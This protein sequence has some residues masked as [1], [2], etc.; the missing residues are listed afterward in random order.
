MSDEGRGRMR[1]YRIEDTGDQCCRQGGIGFDTAGRLTAG[2]TKG[3]ATYISA[4]LG[5]VHVDQYVRLL[6]G[7][8]AGRHAQTRIRL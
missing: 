8:Q 4:Y 1:H 7:R 5:S 6:V 2:D 3:T